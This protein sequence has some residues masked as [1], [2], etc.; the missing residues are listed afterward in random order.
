MKKQLILSIIILNIISINIWGNNVSINYYH[1]G[2][3]VHTQQIE[4]GSAIDSFPTLSLTSC[5]NEINIFVGWI[6]EADA[7]QYQTSN[8]TPPT[9]ITTNYI[10]T[11]DLNL[12]AL[13]ADKA[14]TDEIPW[15]QVKSNTE[16]KDNDKIKH[17][18]AKNN[19]NLIIIL[20][21]GFNICK[22]IPTID[23][24]RSTSNF[25]F[26]IMLCHIRL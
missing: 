13:F 4:Q 8:S 18:F 12:Y 26:S 5:D 1:K 24:H 14:S 16:L 10:P 19:I 17:K 2:A 25:S 20:H 3:I 7:A 9:L 21:A 11:T 15:Q 6:T 22:V 23:Y